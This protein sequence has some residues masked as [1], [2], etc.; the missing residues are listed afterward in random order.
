MHN[1]DSPH[2]NKDKELKQELMDNFE[3]LLSDKFKS[4]K[5]NALEQNLTINNLVGN[6]NINRNR[7][8]LTFAKYPQPNQDLAGSIAYSTQTES[9]LS[10]YFDNHIKNYST[11]WFTRALDRIEA[12]I[13]G[14]NVVQV[15]YSKIAKKAI[16]D[17]MEDA[18]ARLEEIGPIINT[19]DQQR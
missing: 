15:K 10:K 19:R 2:T 7:L 13:T 9:R 6:I 18:A 8:M 1:S 5:D 12:L 14:K 3:K 16:N 4:K 11:S 17:Y